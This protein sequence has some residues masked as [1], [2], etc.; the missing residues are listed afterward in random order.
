[1]EVIKNVIF[2]VIYIWDAQQP[3]TQPTLHSPPAQWLSKSI[4]KLI[5]CNYASGLYSL[6]SNTCHILTKHSAQNLK[7]SERKEHS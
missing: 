2:L 6:F 4:W 5:K 7:L 3:P 1:M